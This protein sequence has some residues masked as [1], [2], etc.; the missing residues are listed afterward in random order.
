MGGSKKLA[1]QIAMI[2]RVTITPAGTYLYGPEAEQMNRV[3]R[4]H[5]DN[6]DS[7]IRVLFAEEDGEQ[8]RYNPQVSNEFVF[9]SRFKS[10]LRNGINIAGRIYNFLGFS[11]SSLRTQSCWFMAQFKFKGILLSD[12]TLIEKL[13]DFSSIRCPAKCAARI[14]QAFSETPIFVSFPSGTV[15]KMK[16]I[17]RNNRVFSDGVGTIS[18]SAIRKIWSAVPSMKETKPTCFQIRYKGT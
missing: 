1:E 15:K 8:V 2:H 4:E 17:K 12:R 6:H 18:D 10:I 5:P 7:F 14:G 13:G 11:H 16:D 3:L 9:N